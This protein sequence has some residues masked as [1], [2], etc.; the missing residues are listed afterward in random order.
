MELIGSSGLNKRRQNS[1]NI[2]KGS[3]R[4]CKINAF[5]DKDG[6]TSK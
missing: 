1:S 3:F 6:E 2:Q 5:T 4:N